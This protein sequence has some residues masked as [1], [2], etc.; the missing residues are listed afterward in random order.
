MA[1]AREGRGFWWALLAMIVATGVLSRVVHTGLRG[2]DKY[3]GDALYAA[4]IYVIF[5]LIGMRHVA[6]WTALTMFAIEAFQLTGIAAEM[7]RSPSLT[8]RICAR[9][10]GTGFSVM[11][12]VAYAVGIGCLWGV[13]RLRR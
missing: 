13:E 5:R 8:V 10:L 12:L 11:D 9:L 7:L 3:P 1:H 2:V 4:M 6:F